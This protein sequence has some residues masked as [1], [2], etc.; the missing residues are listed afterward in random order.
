MKKLGAIGAHK[1]AATVTVGIIALI[2]AGIGISKI[3]VNNNM[4][5]WFKT[6]SEV[7]EADRII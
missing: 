6:G 5:K 7:R 4:V 3:N 1:S 2:I